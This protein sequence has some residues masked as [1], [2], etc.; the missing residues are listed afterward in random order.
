MVWPSQREIFYIPDCLQRMER[1]AVA[2]NRDSALVRL[3]WAACAIEMIPIANEA[4]RQTV[5]KYDKRF[6]ALK[7]LRNFTE[8][9]D[10]YI[11]K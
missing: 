7:K 2:K 4:I 9:Y 8:H 1:I 6:P 11:L 3:S 5:E 10:D